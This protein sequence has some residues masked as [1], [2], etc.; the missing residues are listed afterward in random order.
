MR[1]WTSIAL[2]FGLCLTFW[3]LLSGHFEP[4]VLGLGVAS[5]AAVAW[6]NRDFEVIADVL[7]AGPR[8]VPYVG[9]LLKEIVLANLQV[10]RIVLDPRLPIDPVVV[11]YRAPLSTDL[12]LTTLGNS[13]TLT[14][15]TI[16]VDVEGRE[17]TVHA[18]TRAGADG[19]LEGSMARRIG[20]VF[21]D[22]AA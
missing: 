12:A 14:P 1:Q 16:T 13:I 18:L 17:V 3:L 10:A 6:V 20:R 9:W 7:R 11:R 19:V 8:F 2:V 22:S 15:G 21:R 5:A 4:L